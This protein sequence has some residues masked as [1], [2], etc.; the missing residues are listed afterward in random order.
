MEQK[1][2]VEKLKAVKKL[3]S[4]SLSDKLEKAEDEAEVSVNGVYTGTAKLLENH[5]LVLTTTSAYGDQI[6]V[7]YDDLDKFMDDMQTMVFDDS[8]AQKE[9]LKKWKTILKKF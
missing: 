5:K 7:D 2:E 8:T 4:V 1:E 6:Q 9:D 3:N